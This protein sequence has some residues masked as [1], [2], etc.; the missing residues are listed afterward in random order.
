MSIRVAR[1]TG[2]DPPPPPPCTHE[3]DE[4]GVCIYCGTAVPRVSF[5]CDEHVSVLVFD[6]QDLT[7]EGRENPPFALARSSA[8]G[9]PDP[10]GDGQVNFVLMPE[11]GWLVESVSAEP[12]NFKNLKGPEDIGTE[13]AWRLTKV[14]GDC[15]VT[16]TV[17]ED[18][19]YNPPFRFDDVRDETAFYYEPVYWAVN[20]DPQITNGTSPTTFSPKNTCTRAQVV[21]FLWRACGEPAPETTEHPF[22]D[23]K[24]GAYYEMALLWAVEQGVTTGA[25]ATT[26]RPN[27]GCTRGQVVTFLWRSKGSPAPTVREHTF[28]DVKEDAY[29]YEAMLWAVETGVTTGTSATSFNPN[30]QCTRGQVV[31]FLFRAFGSE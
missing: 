23:V 31:T 25:T 13:N 22:T 3:F 2:E 30:G 1:D 29:Y 28:T 5:A 27:G 18:P 15:T 14:T 16:V 26:F 7:A 4:E 24:A 19:D 8:D 12:A 11:P 6:T 21:T 17:K 10:E 9:S 20:H